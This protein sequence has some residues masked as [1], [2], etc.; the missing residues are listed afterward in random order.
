MRNS[1]DVTALLDDTGLPYGVSL[2]PDFCAEHE[3]GIRGIQARLGIGE[4]PQPPGLPRRTATRPA[5]D[6]LTCRNPKGADGDR[7]DPWGAEGCS[8]LGLCRPAALGDWRGV[9]NWLAIL[10]ANV[11][12]GL[13]GRSYVVEG[14]WDGGGFVLFAQG[15]EGRILLGILRD[16]L[17]SGDAAAWFENPRHRSHRRRLVV[18]VASRVPADVVVR[19]EEEDRE[20][21]A[22]EE[23][24]EATGIRRRLD[25]LSRVRGD[26]AW[27]SRFGY[28]ALSPE[29]RRNVAM[30]GRESAHPVVFWLNPH[31]QKANNMGWYTVEEL[32]AWTDGKGPVPKPVP[33]TGAASHA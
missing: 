31:D 21:E 7:P 17:A 25:A 14:D 1:P 29:W 8:V 4:R 33:A 2:A 18:A 24:A 26:M 5:R 6:H 3:C 30:E 10:A 27:G 9:D 28:M 12:K 20:A 22:L 32:D 13:D 15:A 16:A 11:A 19:L 23:A